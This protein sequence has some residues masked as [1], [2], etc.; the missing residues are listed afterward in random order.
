MT[1]L[2]VG[3]MCLM[4]QPANAQVW[5]DI[6]DNGQYKTSAQSQTPK[7]MDW[8]RKVSTDAGYLKS[9]LRQ[10]PHAQLGA[11]ETTI[12]LPL[13]DGGVSTFALTYSP[14]MAPGLAAKRPDIRTFQIVDT[15]NP[16]NTGRLDITSLGFHGMFKHNGH[17]VFIDPT[18]DKDTY[19]SYYDSDYS[20]KEG[21]GFADRTTCS[22]EHS[23][24]RKSFTQE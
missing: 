7:S 8:S 20:V 12:D 3:A 19:Y 13:P 11:S 22:L 18:A 1:A 24:V 21:L 6:S 15:T 17:R 9:V 5:E 10:A 4:A 2:C 14:I 16:A 23:P